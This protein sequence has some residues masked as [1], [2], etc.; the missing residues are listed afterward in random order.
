MKTITIHYSLQFFH[1]NSSLEESRKEKSRAKLHLIN[2]KQFSLSTTL[3]FLSFVFA[4]LCNSEA[5]IQLP[6]NETIPAVIMFGDSIVDTGN[7][8]DLISAI[9][10]NFPPY[11][12]NFKGGIATGRFSNGKVPSD[13]LGCMKLSHSCMAFEVFLIYSLALWHFSFLFLFL[14]YFT[15][16]FRIMV[17][18]FDTIGS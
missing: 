12:R 9:K 8:N 14:S 5:A 1:L 11:G 2:M 10:C 18:R 4:V 3:L 16:I 15:S 6:K 13:F 7:N 17:T